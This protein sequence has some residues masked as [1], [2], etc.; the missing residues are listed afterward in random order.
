MNESHALPTPLAERDASPEGGRRAVPARPEATA[1]SSGWTAGRIAALVIGALLVLTSLGTLGGGAFALWA[2]RTQRDAAGYVTSGIHAFTTAGFALATEPIELGSP[3]VGWLYSHVLLGEVRIRVTPTGPSSGL[4]VGIGPSGEVDRYLAGVAHTHISDFWSGRTQVAGGN[5]PGSAPGTRD[6][7][8][9][10]TAGRGPQSLLWDPVDGTWT[11]VVMNA[12][13]EQVIDM[14]AE[15]GATMPAL[16]GISVFALVGGGILA[17][18]GALLILGAIRRS[19]AG[20]AR[21][22]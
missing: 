2:D 6:F 7:W 3:G 17:L 8:V 15:L 11:V 1:R 12:D 21:R 9:A 16:L 14:A 4:F 22:V 10:S 19:R 20:V 5:D 18:G 13:G